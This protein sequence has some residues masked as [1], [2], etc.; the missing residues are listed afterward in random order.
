MSVRSRSQSSA[1]RVIALSLGLAAVVAGIGGCGQKDEPQG[2]VA[3]KKRPNILL[4]VADDLGYSDIGAFGSE[5]STP[6]LDWLAA[7]GRLLLD[8]HSAFSCSPTRAMINS[9]T[10]QHVTGIGNQ[11][12]L[13]Y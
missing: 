11:R 1:R 9:G 8:H 2:E 7:E 5:I 3:S 10:D 4:I 6:N 13:D 12:L